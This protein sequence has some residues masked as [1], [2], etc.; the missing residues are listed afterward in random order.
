M[1]K[2]SVETNKS[3]LID[4]KY[5]WANLLLYYYANTTAYILLATLMSHPDYKIHPLK[6]NLSC[7]LLGNPSFPSQFSLSLLPGC[8]A[9]YHQA[10]RD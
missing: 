5:W 3:K 6:R 1:T 8:Q 10:V 7:Q 2:S 4:V 9:I